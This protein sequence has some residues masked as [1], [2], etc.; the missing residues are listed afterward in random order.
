L[1]RKTGSREPSGESKA[2]TSVISGEAF[3]MVIPLLLH[4]RGQLRLRD[5]HAVLNLHLRHVEVRADGEVTVSVR[6]PSFGALV[7]M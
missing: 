4:F 5:G 1:L 7:V 2:T 6:L 3:L